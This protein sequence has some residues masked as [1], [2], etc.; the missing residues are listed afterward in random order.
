ME[1]T[2]VHE[3][4]RRKERKFF[5]KQ[6]ERKKVH[7]KKTEVKKDIPYDMH[8]NSKKT[9]INV[10]KHDKAL[11]AGKYCCQKDNCI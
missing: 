7:R 4:H 9:G 5:K 6:I 1:K 2:K 11:S 8:H 10:W 3:I